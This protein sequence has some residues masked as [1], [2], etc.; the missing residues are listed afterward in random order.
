MRAQQLELHLPT[1]GG[2]REGAGRKRRSER[3]TVPHA[4]RPRFY[5]CNPLLVTVRVRVDVPDLRQREAWSVIVRVLR[6]F[7]GAFP[8]LRV[9]HYGVMS[10]HLHLIVEADSRDALSRGM[11]RLLAQLA[12]RLNARFARH[13]GIVDSRYHARE[14]KSPREVA[15]ALRYVLLNAR[16]HAA[17]HDIGYPPDWF[18]PR[19]TAAI[20]D[21]WRAPPPTR[22]R[23]KDFGTSPPQS[24][25]LRVGW[26]MHGPLDL[27]EV[28][29]RH[30]RANMTPSATSELPTV[31][32]L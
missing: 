21:G 25:L 8:A 1:W 13:G 32:T 9:V 22:E 26:R 3:P 15:N 5:S 4:T 6:W 24:W 19:S 30:A 29:G 18:D 23:S 12:K 28:P 20:F 11:Q 16:H 27:A 7:R 14:L 10:N 2:R 31:L 17:E